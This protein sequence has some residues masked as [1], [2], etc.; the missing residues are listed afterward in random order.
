NWAPG[1]AYMGPSSRGKTSQAD[2]IR[3]ELSAA[4]IPFHETTKTDE[5]GD[6]QIEFTAGEK[7]ER[8]Q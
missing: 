4:G 3:A 1:G 5:P 6:E 8:E 7:P 2:R